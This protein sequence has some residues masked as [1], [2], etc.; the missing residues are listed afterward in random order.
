MNWAKSDA[1]AVGRWHDRLPVLPQNLS[2]KTDD[3]K[4]LGVFLSSKLG[5]HCGKLK[6]WKWLLPQMSYRVLVLNNLVASMLWHRLACMDPPS[7]LLVQLQTKIVFFGMV[8]IGCHRGCCF[9]PEGR[10]A[11]ASSILPAE[12]PP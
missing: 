4:Y 11:R 5:G 3:F 8:C 10:G 1:L 6:K 2:W 7:G 9:Y 12:L